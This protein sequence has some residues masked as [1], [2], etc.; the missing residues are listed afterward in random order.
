MRAGHRLAS[1]R[2][3]K[4]T[5]YMIWREDVMGIIYRG[6]MNGLRKRGMYGGVLGC[7]EPFEMVGSPPCPIS[8]VKH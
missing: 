2:K 3:K 1:K 4:S 7:F 6:W 5:P 8:A